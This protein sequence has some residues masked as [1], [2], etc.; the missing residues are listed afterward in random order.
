MSVDHGWRFA[1]TSAM[2]AFTSFFTS[3][4]GSGLASGNRTVPFDV[5]YPVSAAAWARR[6]AVVIG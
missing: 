1:R 4:D 6:I 2:R 3:D 5:P